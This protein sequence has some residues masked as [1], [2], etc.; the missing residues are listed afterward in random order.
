M[1][2]RYV[3]LRT[4]EKDGKAVALMGDSEIL[5]DSGVNSLRLAFRAHAAPISRA[6]V[7]AVTAE[8]LK[9]RLPELEKKKMHNSVEAYKR[10]I[11]CVEKKSG[12]KPP[13]PGDHKPHSPDTPPPR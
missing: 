5:G 8:Q 6:G 13:E 11:E 4:A 2:D 10:A 3:F 1:K 12:G 7:T 9:E